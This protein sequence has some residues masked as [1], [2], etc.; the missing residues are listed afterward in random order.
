MQGST[1]FDVVASGEDDTV[2]LPRNIVA[3]F[4]AASIAVDERARVVTVTSVQ[5]EI[6]VDSNAWAGY[7]D[8]VLG[9]LLET[10]RTPSV[11]EKPLRTPLAELLHD[12]ELAYI[13]ALKSDLPTDKLVELY[14]QIQVLGFPS[15]SDLLGACVIEELRELRNSDE[16]FAAVGFEPPN[17]KTKAGIYDTIF[18]TLGDLS[19]ER[20]TAAQ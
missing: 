9:P 5:L 17:A 18:Q 20:C 19:A 8:T 11:I 7:A 14:S 15:L 3:L 2:S 1:M 13:A 16:V 10:G 12:E 6:L 4:D